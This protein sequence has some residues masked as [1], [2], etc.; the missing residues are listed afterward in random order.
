MN[1]SSVDDRYDVAVV[2]GGPAGA[3]A[4]ST[5]CQRGRDVLLA[6]ASR[7]DGWRLGETLFP[8]I[9]E[10]LA[11]LGVADRFD[12]IPTVPS[13][14]IRSCWGG[15]EPRTRSFITSPY[16][17]GWHLDRATFD[18]M[19]VNAARRVGATATLGTRVTACEFDS[20][21]RTA[22]LTLDRKS[23]ADAGCSSASSTPVSVH[24][25]GVLDATGRTATL[26]R[27]LGS[28]REVRDR[29]VGAAAQ[30][31]AE[32]D[33][34]GRYTLIEA[35]PD[36]WWYSAPIPDGRLVVI[37]FTDT[38]LLGDRRRRGS[39]HD[40]VTATEETSTRLDGA[41]FERGP[42][43]VA[44]VSHRLRRN[45]GAA[46]WLAVGDAA[47]GVDPL[48]GSGI[49]RAI[50]TGV[51]GA[52][53]IDRWLDGVRVPAETYERELDDEF[54]AYLDRWAAYYALED[55]WPDCPFW[56]RRHDPEA[57]DP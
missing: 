33:T 51:R 37:W 34:C 3:V 42:K 5:L 36:G 6:E 38:D 18:R 39:W 57:Y 11:A 14:G 35:M 15:T 29:L 54:D 44:A 26:A 9:R 20:D 31:Q 1:S 28:Q 53:A 2:G 30:F 13:N 10:P 40:A 21:D 41:S 27:Q 23:V 56:R 16:D 19:L 12:A 8:S 47:M 25:D 4:A 48:S 55:R 43:V 17:G 46:R 7:Y 52:L 49:E 45:L 22:T 50:D 24:A 32:H